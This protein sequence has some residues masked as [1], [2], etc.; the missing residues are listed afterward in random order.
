MASGEEG[1]GIA[2][3][4]ARSLRV[5]RAGPSRVGYHDPYQSPD[6]LSRKMSDRLD[7]DWARSDVAGKQ[8]RTW[9]DCRTRTNGPAARAPTG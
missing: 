3:S 8:Y 6:G 9:S 1:Y 4:P 7:E 2:H 5:T